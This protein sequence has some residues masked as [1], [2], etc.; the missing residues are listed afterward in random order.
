MRTS[1]IFKVS[2]RRIATVLA[3]TLLALFQCG[4]DRSPAPE[5]PRPPAATTLHRGLGAEPE[6]LDPQLASD[7][8]ALAV[9]GDLYEG[10]P[11]ET[12]DGRIGAGAA[13]SWTVSPD[14]LTWTFQLRPRLHWSNG[15]PLTADEFVAALES[16]IAPD[17]RAPNAGLL[18]SIAKIAPAG[19]NALLINLK[20]P[21]PQLPALLA[22]PLGAPRHRASGDQASVVTNGP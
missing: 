3:T 18:E 17:S 1:C 8:A 6:T 20:C 14:G 22:L 13:E 4:C 12:A 5:A 19:P 21:L 11:A 7:N 9:L 2:G 15:D 16:V 10:L